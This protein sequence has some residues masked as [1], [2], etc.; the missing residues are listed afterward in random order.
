MTV[1]KKWNVPFYLI[2]ETIWQIGKP[3]YLTASHSKSSCRK[4]SG[5]IPPD[6][7]RGPEPPALAGNSWI[8]AFA[9]MRMKKKRVS[10]HSFLLLLSLVQAGG[11]P[12]APFSYFLF[13]SFPLLLPAV[14]HTHYSTRKRDFIRTTTYGF[15]VDR[16]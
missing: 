5:G 4:G 13:L 16:Q 7:I 12:S 1:T 9:G 11:F 14:F 6:S 3:V 15:Q 10:S 8:P 2:V